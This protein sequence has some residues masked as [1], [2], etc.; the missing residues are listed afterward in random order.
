METIVH[1]WGA[2][3]NVDANV[4]AIREQAAPLV[5]RSGSVAS[6]AEQAHYMRVAA[7]L[8]VGSKADRNRHVPL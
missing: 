8:M 2:Q 5:V 3:A 6:L 4:G 1:Y 7:D